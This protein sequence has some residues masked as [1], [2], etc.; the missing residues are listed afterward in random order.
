MAKSL[1]MILFS[2]TLAVIGQLLLKSGMNSVGKISTEDIRNLGA[3]VT[4]VITNYHVLLGLSLY[5]IS[6]IVWLVILSRVNLSFA[7]PLV[8]F[9]YVV[10]MFAS[11][12]FFNEPISP[13]RWAG[14]VLI[15]IGV[16]FISR[17]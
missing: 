7:Y 4:K 2:I 5:V 6:A 14:A 3:T 16:V 10:V 9:S 17:T 12:V 1:L 13:I 15:S 11:R 8:G